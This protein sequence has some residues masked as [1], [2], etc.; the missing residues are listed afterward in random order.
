MDPSGQLALAFLGVLAVICLV[1]WLA[2]KN[3]S[4]FA[5]IIATAKVSRAEE[6]QLE[7]S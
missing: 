6:H 3:I 1:G 2:Y 4:T 7:G 5:R